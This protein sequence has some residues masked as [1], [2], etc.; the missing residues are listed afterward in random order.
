[1]RYLISGGKGFIGNYISNRLVQE[2]IHVKTLGRSEENDFQ[3]DLTKDFIEIVED[4]DIIIHTASIVHNPK[5]AIDFDPVLL[6][7]DLNITQNFLKSIE[8][9]YYK[10]L[11]FLSSVSIYGIDSGKNIDI[12]Q[13]IL[14]KTGYGLSKAMS[15]KIF[16]EKVTREKLLIIRL[17]LVNGQNP[18]G[19]IKKALDSIH[20][21]K[22]VLF[23]GNKAEKSIL[24]LDDLYS[25]I[26]N[27]SLTLN[28]IHQIKSYDIRFNDFILSLSSKKIHS[29]PIQW[30]YAM[31]F[32]TSLFRMKKLKNTLVKVSEDLTFK[33]S[34]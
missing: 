6:Q 32:I 29:I 22:M 5:H 3:I 12:D 30:L 14:P 4:F 11:I 15:E 33:N 9:I 23:K 7:M 16:L 10:K 24:E 20:S 19:N 28:G 27:N 8:K 17:P 31:I 21:R 34:F 26:Q 13:E 1:M 25:F 18:K 2:N